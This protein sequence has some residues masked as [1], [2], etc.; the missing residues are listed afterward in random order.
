MEIKQLYN[1]NRLISYGTDFSNKVVFHLYFPFGLV[2]ALARLILATIVVLLSFA[3]PNYKFFHDLLHKSMCIACGLSVNIK[4]SDKTKIEGANL[5]VSNHVSILDHLAVH[6]V[7]DAVLPGRILTPLLAAVCGT[8]AF[9]TRTSITQHLSTPNIQPLYIHPEGVSTNG[10][11]LLKFETWPFQH[12]ERVQPI[13]ITIAR[14]TPLNIAV[15]TIEGTY[16]TD[17]FFYLFSPYTVYE[18]TFLPICE[19]KSMGDEEFAEKIRRDI[20]QCLQIS[21]ADFNMSEVKEFEKKYKLELYRPQQQQFTNRIPPELQNMG[22]MV[23]EVLPMVPINV[24]YKDLVRTRNVDQT[25]TNILEGNVSYSPELPSTPTH[26]SSPLTAPYPNDSSP[27]TSASYTTASVT[28]LNN[29]VNTADP[30]CTAAQSFGKSA[31]ERM[32]SFQERKE[33]LIENARRRYL[34]KHGM[35]NVA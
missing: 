31:K 29:R 15:S 4:T 12:V 25:I 28:L 35:K 2:L 18:L 11:A 19:K 13:A 8:K 1:Y 24:I 33:L 22:R 14:P 30:M 26:S 27:S 3:L 7:T 9:N 16:L 5:Y 34:A 21:C 32:L 20:A 6:S 17:L 10:R 23:K